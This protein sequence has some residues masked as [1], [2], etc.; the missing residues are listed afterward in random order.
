MISKERMMHEM[1][2]TLR[3]NFGYKAEVE[4]RELPVWRLVAGPKALKALKT[5]GGVRKFFG[6][7]PVAGVKVQNYPINDFFRLVTANLPNDDRIP[8]LNSTGIDF[9]VD[10]NIQTDMTDFTSVQNALNQYGLSLVKGTADMKV[11]VIR[12]NR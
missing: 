2:E 9:C 11:L 12:D 4:N 10:A 6:L 7:H 5:K 1:Q 3:Q 8:Y